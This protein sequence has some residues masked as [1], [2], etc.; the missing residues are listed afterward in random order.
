MVDDV[1]YGPVTTLQLAQALLARL[2]RSDRSPENDEESLDLPHTPA[3]SRTYVDGPVCCYEAVVEP[4][5]GGWRARE[6]MNFCEAT[7]PT[8]EAA[9]EA[10]AVALGETMVRRRKENLPMPV[11]KPLRIE[12]NHIVGER[13]TVR[14]GWSLFT[15]T[16]SH[17]L[18]DADPGADAGTETDHQPADVGGEREVGLL[19]RLARQ[20]R[21]A[22]SSTG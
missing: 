3:V 12:G 14:D 5:D 17:P 1:V 19:E 22:T 2:G 18:A 7:G 15:V 9:K 13:T 6:I 11:P 8:P 4:Y 21:P 16:P 10:L 20:V